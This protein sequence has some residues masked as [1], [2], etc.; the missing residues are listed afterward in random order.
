M[1][2]PPWRKLS[3]PY[4][5][6]ELMDHFVLQVFDGSRK[7]YEVGVVRLPF[8]IGRGAENDLCLPSSSVSRRHASI[9]PV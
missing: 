2:R 1:D 9:H 4:P 7:S 5:S 8:T 3:E 6:I